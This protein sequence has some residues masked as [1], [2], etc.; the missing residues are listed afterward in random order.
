LFIIIKPTPRISDGGHGSSSRYKDL[1]A[2]ESGTYAESYVQSHG[3]FWNHIKSVIREAGRYRESTHQVNRSLQ[4]VR[5]G[6]E[7]LIR[8]RAHHDTCCTI[9]G[10]CRG[11]QSCHVYAPKLP[12]IYIDTDRSF[13]QKGHVRLYCKT[14]K[15]GKA[16]VWSGGPG[17]RPKQIHDLDYSSLTSYAQEFGMLLR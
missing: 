15:S 2:S 7:N 3:Q 8:N 11:S 12:R 17:W 9:D 4:T 10:T 13:S 5:V 6:L 16:R 1:T 14:R